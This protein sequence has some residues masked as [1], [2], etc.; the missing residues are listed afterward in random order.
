ML[1]S[2]APGI[3]VSLF[4]GYWEEQV[5]PPVRIATY[6]MSG[7]LI[8]AACGLIITTSDPRTSKNRSSPS[9]K[10]G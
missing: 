3:G 10:D 1:L 9:P 6:V 7:I 8:V 5:P 4:R 2:L